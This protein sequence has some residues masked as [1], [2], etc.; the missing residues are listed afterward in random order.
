M[1]RIS[2]LIYRINDPVLRTMFMA[3]S[4]RFWMR[5]G[6]VDMLAGNLR[7]NLRSM[8]PILC[9]KTAFHLQSALH[10]RG[11]GG[12]LPEMPRATLRG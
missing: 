6:I 8:L 5:D 11:F 3:P 7:G 10:R 1:D 12:E 2:W 9:F 4:N